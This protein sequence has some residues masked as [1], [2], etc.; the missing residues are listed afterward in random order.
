MQILDLS[1]VRKLVVQILL[2]G[3]LVYVRD[4]DDPAFNRADGG[5]IGVGAH[6]EVLRVIFVIGFGGEGRVNLHFG[7]C[8]DDG[9]DLKGE[10][11]GDG[12]NVEGATLDLV[13]L[14][15]C[16][17][18]SFREAA[19]QL[20]HHHLTTAALSLVLGNKLHRGT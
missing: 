4:N 16:C 11:G 3:F 19:F 9:F 7:V 12:V 18:F 17:N 5:R 8:H 13:S 15:F 14:D 1:K 10:D 6:R 2:A 20:H